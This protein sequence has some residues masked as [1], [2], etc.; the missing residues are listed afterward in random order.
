MLRSVGTSRLVGRD[1][2]LE[3]LESALEQA[4]GGRPSVTLVV[5]EYGIGKTRLMGELEVRAERQGIRV[6]GG[7]CVP[8]E[9]TELPYGPIGSGLRNLP[10]DVLADALE[11]LPDSARA[12]LASAFPQLAAPA[13]TWHEA[14][15]GDLHQS[16]FYE[17]LL[18]LLQT[19]SE[20]SPLLVIIEDFHWA[21]SATRNFVS[22]LVR[23]LRRQRIALVVTDRMEDVTEVDR[24]WMEDLS[25]R[26]G[27]V[28]L[29]G[30]DRAAVSE[31]LASGLGETPPED[32]VDEVFKRSA[33]N[34]FFAEELLAARM[35]ARAGELPA[36]L[37]DALITRVERLSPDTQRVVLAAAAVARACGSPLLGAVASLRE[38]ELSRAVRE[39]LDCNVLEQPSGDDAFQFRH[40]VVREVV[41]EHLLPG[42]RADLHARV[43]ATM[44]ELGA[45]VGP[46][47]LAYHWRAAGRTGE[48]IAASLDAARA[49]YDA[50]AY[51]EALGHFERALALADEAGALPEAEDRS[52]LLRIAAETAR[53]AGDNTRAIAL[54][55]QALQHVDAAEDPVRAALLH[56]LWGHCQAFSYEAALRGF[57]TALELLPASH[58]AD[59]ARLLG[60]EANALIGVG[61]WPA[62]EEA[63]R[64]A[65]TALELATD[66]GARAEE[67]HA[68]IMLGFAVALLGRP[69]EGAEHLRRARAI[70]RELGHAEDLLRSSLYL[71]EVLRLGGDFE[72]ALEEMVEGRRRAIELGMDGSF[73]RYMALNSAEDLFRLGRWDGTQERL[74]EVE[75]ERDPTSWNRLLWSLLAGQLALARGDVDPADAQLS[76]ALAVYEDVG[77]PAEYAATL[78]AALAELVLA[79]REYDA[80]RRHID[81]GRAAIAGQAHLLY[82]PAL[83]SI[84]GRVEAEAA[85]AGR[86]PRPQAARRVV[87]LRDA[88]AE[89]IREVPGATPPP[90]ALAH[91][92][93]CE[94]ELARAS[95]AAGTD[96]WEEAAARWDAIG[97]PYEAAYARAH[98]AEAL[99]QSRGDRGVAVDL[100]ARAYATAAQLGAAQ[101]RRAVELLAGRDLVHVQVRAGAPE[102]AEA[103]RDFD[104]TARERE[105]LALLAAGLTNRAI[106][107]RLVISEKTAGAHVSNI[108]AKL[109]VH[110]RRVAATRALQLGLAGP[111]ED[112]G[113]ASGS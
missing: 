23:N 59:R 113:P 27:R 58:D 12:L 30:L 100:L 103:A 80:A 46:G 95:G 11:P 63:G 93:L 48:A 20:T 109:D 86:L 76:Q 96:H 31:L 43:A 15:P 104:L 53:Y 41:Y 81:T 70:A 47:E 6:L 74:E 99:L 57:R 28:E 94:A 1:E 88:L 60:A 44:V 82:P 39:A 32:L 25:K 7:E 19:L 35:S 105:V 34:P 78:H 72:A 17:F 8:L 37:K 16:R 54:V 56:E 52:E 90:I 66:V 21:D 77:R 4:R 68:R 65:T 33:G 71:G 55:E 2:D 61:T 13:G 40:D 92:A 110:D 29:T 49:T 112:G 45:A 79:R 24:R 106:A 73:G 97:A 85:D 75:I 22:F 38:P 18:T 108:F 69:A 84:G 51:S 36:T 67:A 107:E 98:H 89:M 10:R 101:L 87:E 83:F 14:P 5:G 102:T 91:L 111:P 3:V 62:V 26:A 42:E 9:G 64:Q 50:H